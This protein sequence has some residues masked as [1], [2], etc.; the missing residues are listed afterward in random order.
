MG[1]PSQDEL[2][3]MRPTTMLSPNSDGTYGPADTA[4]AAQQRQTT[5][6][7]ELRPDGGAPAAEPAQAPGPAA[8][9]PAV[10]E[11]ASGDAS[12]SGEQAPKDQQQPQGGEQQ[13]TGSE[14]TTAPAASD[15]MFGKTD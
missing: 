5:N 9:G 4:P 3:D 10:V 7:T 6:V 11:P 8:A 12:A 1:I 2:E 14:K 15:D 13:N